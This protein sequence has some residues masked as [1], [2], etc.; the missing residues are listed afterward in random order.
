VVS[1]VGKPKFQFSLIISSTR[2]LRVRGL[3]TAPAPKRRKLP[4]GKMRKN[5]GGREPR[6]SMLNITAKLFTSPEVSHFI[7][8]LTTVLFTRDDLV[9]PMHDVCKRLSHIQHHKGRSIVVKVIKEARKLLYDYLNGTIGL[10]KSDILYN[11][12]TSDRLP[13]HLYEL[14][15]HIR[16][17]NKETLRCVLSLLSCSR[18]FIPL[19]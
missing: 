15:S 6:R 3:R 5:F 4:K 19:T 18:S 1:L 2:S 10:K 8:W 7:K 13:V 16:S 12:L 17:K 9:A 14:L 11:R